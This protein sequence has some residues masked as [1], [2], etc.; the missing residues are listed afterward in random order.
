MATGAMAARPKPVDECGELLAN[1]RITDAL[2]D[3]ELRAPTV[4]ASML[5]GQFVHLKLPGMDARIL[6]RPFSVYAAD[7]EAGTMR[8]LYQVV[9]KGS[10]HMATLA[11]GR[12]GAIG[13]MGPMGNPWQL[14]EGARR[15]LFVLGG[16]GAA[17]LAMFG[18]QVVQAGVGLDVCMGAQTREALALKAHYEEAIGVKPVFATDDG[19]FGHAGF[20]T[21]PA[22]ELLQ[23]N[24]YD[25][26]CC[27]GPEPLMRAVAGLA[28]DAGVAC[29]VSLEKRMACG[30][31]ACLSCVV[32]TVDGR[33]RSCVDGPVFEAQEV[34]W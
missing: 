21:G 1:R 24:S 17:P 11:P 9:G 26:V 14:P 7:A 19:S 15:V 22:A 6:R 5:P 23:R 29:Q 32:D 33:K 20:V 27:C 28:A 4:A 16:V 2:W 18:R 10:A 3:M 25:L 34:V 8:I 12:A 31:G 13:V 30:I